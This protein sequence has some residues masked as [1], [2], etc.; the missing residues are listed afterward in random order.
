MKRYATIITIIALLLSATIASAN[1]F[2]PDPVPPD[3]N[4]LS[5]SG[6]PLP[7][8]LPI[9]PPNPEIQ[10]VTAELWNVENMRGMIQTYQTML[11]LIQQNLFV[12][13]IFTISFFILLLGWIVSYIKARENL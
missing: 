2:L 11:V 1:D 3:E 9:P 4:P 13:I 5:Q 6:S 12:S 7:G 8:P 10:E